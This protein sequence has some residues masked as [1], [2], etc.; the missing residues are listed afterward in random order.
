MPF[1]AIQR[2]KK[3]F[4][5]QYKVTATTQ[6]SSLIPT[7]LAA[8][9]TRI[10]MLLKNQN[11]LVMI[12]DGRSHL[13]EILN[14]VVR[15]CDDDFIPQQLCIRLKHL[16]KNCDG[17]QLAVLITRVICEEYELKGKQFI[18]CLHDGASINSKAIR[19][20]A[21]M[22]YNAVDINCFS[23]MLNNAGKFNNF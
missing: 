19:H 12:F 17:E 20:M 11:N 8:E 15:W 4:S 21:T 10:K 22:L 14:I 2:V 18:G 9:K 1:A 16:D 6:L 5:H 13:G 3:L 7:V 23:H